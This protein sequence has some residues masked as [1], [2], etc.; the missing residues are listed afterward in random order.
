MRFCREVK[1]PPL[2]QISLMLKKDPGVITPGLTLIDSDLVI[3]M[4]SEI[5]LVAASQKD[6]LFVSAF[7]HL[8]AEDLGKAA[9]IKRWMDENTDLLRQEYAA[10]GNLSS[11]EVRILFLCAGIDPYAFCLLPLLNNLPLEVMR[12]RSIESGTEKWLTIEKVVP[13]EFPEYEVGLPPRTC[14]DTAPLPSFKK[15]R[16]IELTDAEINDFFDSAPAPAK[17]TSPSLKSAFAPPPDDGLDFNGPY[18][19]KTR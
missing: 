17:N 11:F 18:F 15:Y 19:T 3:P 6:L 12:Y 10:K 4:V 1:N 2:S 13:Q 8:T 16:P 14:N 7:T 9:G 5:D